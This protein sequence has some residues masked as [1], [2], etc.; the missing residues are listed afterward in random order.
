MPVVRP[1]L[2]MPSGLV[3]A[4][5]TPTAARPTRIAEKE[6]ARWWRAAG[7]RLAAGW[8]PGPDTVSVMAPSSKAE[9]KN[10]AKR[11]SQHG[12]GHAHAG[13]QQ[14]RQRAHGA[15]NRDSVAP[16]KIAALRHLPAPQRWNGR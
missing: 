16:R 2:S 4:N 15:T 9:T 11:K 5:N 1:S 14:L 10:S 8:L 6:R 7:A 12:S 3:D 13:E